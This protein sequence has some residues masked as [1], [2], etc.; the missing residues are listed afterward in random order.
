[1]KVRAD[2]KG[3]GILVKRLPSQDSSGEVLLAVGGGRSPL[4]DG[5]EQ[6][7]LGVDGCPS[8]HPHVMSWNRCEGVAFQQDCHGDD[9][10]HESK[11]VPNALPWAPAEGDVPAHYNFPLR[12]EERGDG[13]P[14]LSAFF[15]CPLQCFS[16]PLHCWDILWP[17]YSTNHM[18]KGDL[19]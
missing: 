14:C 15:F 2:S 12:M 16:C 10:L 11:L 7:I 13:L 5:H 17:I 6:A 9:S 3:R 19:G 4:I 1:M 8:C 18:Q